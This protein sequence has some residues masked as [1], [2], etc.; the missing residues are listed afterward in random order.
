MSLNDFLLF[1]F[2]KVYT[3]YVVVQPG[4]SFTNT[5]LSLVAQKLHKIHMNNQEKVTTRSSKLKVH[6]ANLQTISWYPVR[7]STDIPFSFL[8]S[9]AFCL[10][11]F[12]GVFF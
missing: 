3:S 12:S 8:V 9:F 10:L 6:R 5:V 7:F 11:V 4:C 2:L 1:L